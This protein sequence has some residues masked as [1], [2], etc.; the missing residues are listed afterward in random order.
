MAAPPERARPS[1]TLNAQPRIRQ[2]SRESEK[3]EA[4]T[5]HARL[6]PQRPQLCSLNGELTSRKTSGS[7][8]RSSLEFDQ[9]GMGTNCE[10]FATAL[11]NLEWLR[12]CL[13]RD[14]STIATDSKGFSALHFAAQTCKLACL[15]VLIEE[16]KFPVDLCTNSGQTPLHLVIHRD[17]KFKALPCIRYLL[18]KGAALNCQTSNGSTPLHLA[19]REGLMSIVKV[20]VKNGADVH[21]RDIRGYKA[22]DYCKLWNDRPCARFLKDA[23]W[24]QDK[25]DIS[26]EK[27]KLKQLK[28]QLTVMELNFL[29]EYQR[30]LQIRIDEDYR[31]WLRHKL[32]LP[33]PA[34]VSGS[35]A[36]VPLV[37]NLAEMLPSMSARCTQE[38]RRLLAQQEQLQEA[39]KAHLTQLR[40]ASKDHLTQPQLA[41]KARLTQPQVQLAGWNF[42]TNPARAPVTQIGRPQG[43]RLGVQPDPDPEHDLSCFLEVSVPR[44]GHAQLLT[45][46]GQK[47]VP[48]PRLPFE[49]IFGT[50]CPSQQPCRMKVP[51]GLRP[52]GLSPVPGKRHW[53]NA[54]WT[55]TLAMNL[56]ETF[57]D[58][59]VSAVRAHQ[60]PP[61]PPSP[62]G[63][64]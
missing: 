1:A 4:S 34:L 27:D 64:P 8:L 56:R 7:V 46:T 36:R 52:E 49:V 10:L 21:A 53:A 24:R 41:S 58:A 33:E 55:D 9:G 48:L 57:E 20:L 45:R 14:R 61:S 26:S 11:G 22:I 62:M 59:F 44:S 16:Y 50:L 54:F 19:A 47:V 42:C 18:R 39:S 5:L 29:T 38:A 40:E 13:N 3:G 28:D 32:C 51:E 63:P 17:N 2:R 23:M 25:R 15:Q 60:G 43:I 37:P 30:S 6:L 35:S 12:F 31:K